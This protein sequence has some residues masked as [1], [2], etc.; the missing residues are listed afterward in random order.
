MCLRFRHILLFFLI[1]H[2]A[3]AA[4][5][6]LCGGAYEVA[7]R[8]RLIELV[9]RMAGPLGEDRRIAWNEFILETQDELRRYLSRS[10]LRTLGLSSDEIENAVS[11]AYL[12]FE[13]NIEKFEN[14]LAGRNPVLLLKRIAERRFFDEV[15]RLKSLR[16]RVRLETDLDDGPY[17]DS[18]QVNSRL[19]IRS[20][21]DR[22]IVDHSDEPIEIENNDNV[23]PL[24]QKVVTEVLKGETANEIA[25]RLSISRENV[26]EI[27]C[28]AISKLR[29]HRASGVRVPGNLFFSQSQFLRELD[30]LND[31]PRRN[32][33]ELRDIMWLKVAKGLSSKEVAE[34]LEAKYP[35]L[36]EFKVN[37]KVFAVMTEWRKRFGLSEITSSRVRVLPSSSEWRE[38]GLRLMRQRGLIP[39]SYYEQITRNFTPRQKRV[40]D[41]VFIRG[42]TQLEI[43]QTVAKTKETIGLIKKELHSRWG[44]PIS[45]GY[46]NY[47]VIEDGLIPPLNLPEA[48]H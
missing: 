44:Y 17:T 22:N 43:E 26:P 42:L 35:G 45:P 29:T 39:R 6:D 36:N 37:N 34:Q 1:C 23:T 21:V 14:E 18:G 46:L 48:G 27:Y 47:T 41:L 40:S 28:E 20:A 12:D 32:H 24:E 33:E 7:E 4:S 25:Q 19:D 10:K 30:S 38:G 13:K 5:V 31:H 2:G 11:D 15:E 8:I 16:S 9:T 3:I